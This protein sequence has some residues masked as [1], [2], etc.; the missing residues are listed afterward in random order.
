[1]SAENPI[2]PKAIA[3]TTGAGLGAAVSTLIIWVLGVVGWHGSAAASKVA[4]T[5]AAVPG[6]VS[7]VVG[8]LIP[9]GLAAILGWRVVDPNRVTAEEL[10]ILRNAQKV[11]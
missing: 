2:S 5:I 10:Q 6:P 9:A 4:E 1:M 3:S 11:S 8:L 7:A